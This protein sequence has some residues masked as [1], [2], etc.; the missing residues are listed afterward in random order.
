MKRGRYWMDTTHNEMFLSKKE[1][2]ERR[3]VCARVRFGWPRQVR[4][5]HR[6]NQNEGTIAAW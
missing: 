2:S 1:G 6:D 3:K 4:A 5:K